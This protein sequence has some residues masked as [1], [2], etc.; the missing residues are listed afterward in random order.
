MTLSQI[1]N[2]KF[3]VLALPERAKNLEI[4]LKKGGVFLYMATWH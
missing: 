3:F 2:M 4:W 1:T